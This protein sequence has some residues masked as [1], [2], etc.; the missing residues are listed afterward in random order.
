MELLRGAPFKHITSQFSSTETGKLGFLEEASLFIGYIGS[1][2]PTHCISSE[3]NGQVLTQDCV[4]LHCIT[5]SKAF[6]M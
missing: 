3:L 4:T 6:Q 1:L 5:L 2:T